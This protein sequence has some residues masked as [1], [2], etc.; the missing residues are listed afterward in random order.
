MLSYQPRCPLILEH[1][2]TTNERCKRLLCNRAAFRQSW[3]TRSGLGQGAAV[4]ALSRHGA[5]KSSGFQ[6]EERTI[7]PC[8]T[9]GSN[10]TREF[11]L[12][13]AEVLFQLVVETSLK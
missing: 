3:V 10:A 13:Q 4:Q 8:L 9:R 1:C 12:R 2:G 5:N 7:A 11:Y 6:S